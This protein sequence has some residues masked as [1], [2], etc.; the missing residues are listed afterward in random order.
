M[1]DERAIAA[2]RD[3]LARLR[4]LPPIHTFRPLSRA[5]SAAWLPLVLR[6]LRRRFEGLTIAP[7]ADAAAVERLRAALPACPPELPAF[8]AVCGGLDAHCDCY[9]EIY[10]AERMLEVR[11]WIVE[12][13]GTRY[14]PLRGDGCGGEDCLVVGPGVAEGA[15][16]FCDREAM[17]PTYV[18]A[19][20]LWTYLDLWSDWLVH[21]F[22]PDGESIDRAAEFSTALMDAIRRDH[23]DVD[24]VSVLG[25]LLDMGGDAESGASSRLEHPWPFDERWMRRRDP[26]L[27]ALFDSPEVARWLVARGHVGETPAP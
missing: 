16:V 18:C 1:P 5:P 13:W 2:V 11:G 22:E 26:G 25:A 10:G 15:V 7:P 12:P 14:V 3:V 17:G 24:R 27:A 23:P 4:R 20:G 21:S 6:R 19:S 9:G 8:L